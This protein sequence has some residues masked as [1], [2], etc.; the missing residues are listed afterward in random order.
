[1]KKQDS[2][3]FIEMQE[4]VVAFSNGEAHIAKAVCNAYGDG[5]WGIKFSDYC[6]KLMQQGFVVTDVRDRTIS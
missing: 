6:L 3:N 4:L 2:V 5:G 1:M